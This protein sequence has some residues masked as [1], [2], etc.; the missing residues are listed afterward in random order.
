MNFQQETNETIYHERQVR[1]LCALHALNNLFQDRTAFSKNELDSI[2]HTLSP[3][4]WINPHRSILGLGNY[5]V[6]VI[7]SALQSRG[8]D[9]IWFDKR[10]DPSCLNLQNIVGFILNIPSDYKF[11]FITIPLRR[12]HWIAIRN[13]YGI[14]YNL[15]SKLEAPKSIGRSGEL[16]HF[17]RSELDSQDKELFVVTDCE[18]GRSQG[19]LKEDSNYNN[20]VCDSQNRDA[21]EVLVCDITDLNP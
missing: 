14:Y 20:K 21:E 19:W 2:C 13:L 7:M 6:N 5:D 3:E 1:E 18:T 16:E 8:Y 15:D 4:N 17:I 12:R 10:K 9:M 11:S